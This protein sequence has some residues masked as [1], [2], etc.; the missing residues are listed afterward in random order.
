MEH[1]EERRDGGRMSI[2]LAYTIETL[3]LVIRI[4]RKDE[5]TALGYHN[6][7]VSQSVTVP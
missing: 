3:I 2:S 6:K 5:S 4:E 1:K 7:A